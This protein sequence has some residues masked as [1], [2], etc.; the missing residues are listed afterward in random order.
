MAELVVFNQQSN[1]ISNGSPRLINLFMSAQDR[2]N[3][4][5]NLALSYDSRKRIIYYKT[6]ETSL[7]ELLDE[8]IAR[9]GIRARLNT[10]LVYSLFI[11]FSYS[12]CFQ[13]DN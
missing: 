3:K 1:S 10:K 4:K 5:I 9:Q 7:E 8:N 12:K 2:F 13:S 11:G 6:Y